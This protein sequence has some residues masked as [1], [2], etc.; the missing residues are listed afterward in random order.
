MS[1]LK[2]G[3]SGKPV[4]QLQHALNALGASLKPDGKFGAKTEDAVR[5]FQGARGLLADGE[6]DAKTRA[7]IV[8]WLAKPATTATTEPESAPIVT[9]PAPI[10]TEPAPIVTEPAAC[11]V[12]T[13]LVQSGMH[14]PPVM[15]TPTSRESAFT[16]DGW[17]KAAQRCPAHAK[18][19]GGMI[20]AGGAVVHA[21]ERLSMDLLLGDWARGHGG[22]SAHFVIGQ[23]AATAEESATAF[24]SAGLVQTI[25]ITRGSKHA[26]G[27]NGVHG[28]LQCGTELL[29]PDLHYVGIALH[30]ACRLQ[31]SAGVAIDPRTS[32]PLDPSDVFVDE[33]GKPWHRVT[34]YQLETLGRLLDDLDEVILPFPEGAKIAPCGS[35][36]RTGTAWAYR[37]DPRFVGH[38]TLDPLNHSDPGPQVMAWLRSRYA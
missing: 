13:H 36:E 29:H 4:E 2:K 25:P 21:T 7:A 31:W 35:Y 27:P 15:G 5:G 10:V 22:T 24:P 19:T 34:E 32:R 38:V 20:S 28:W 37:S 18:L 3:S 17:Y 23:R 12:E 6:V 9:E 16:A 33:R 30:S 11:D 26:G 8:E 1:T 14:A